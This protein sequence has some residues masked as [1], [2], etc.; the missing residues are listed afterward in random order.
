[1]SIEFTFLKGEEILERG[2]TAEEILIVGI[3]YNY[4]YMAGIRDREDKDLVQKF[5]DNGEGG[6]KCILKG[7]KFLWGKCSRF[8]SKARRIQA[9]AD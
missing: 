7:A 2:L 4:G 6:K 3:G 9:I 1:M 5:E 8:W